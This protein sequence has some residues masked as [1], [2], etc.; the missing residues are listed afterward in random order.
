MLEHVGARSVTSAWNLFKEMSPTVNEGQDEEVLGSRPRYEAAVVDKHSW[1][2]LL[3]YN[4][5][6]IE[7]KVGEVM[8]GALEELS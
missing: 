2:A 1:A 7:G 4:R 3:G 8:Q 6:V 5:Q